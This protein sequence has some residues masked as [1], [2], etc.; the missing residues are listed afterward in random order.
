MRPYGLLQVVSSCPPSLE[1]VRG[2]WVA[3]RVV[4]ELRH[5]GHGLGVRQDIRRIPRP[6]IPEKPVG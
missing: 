4:H 1:V 6:L 3:P 5:L 2:L